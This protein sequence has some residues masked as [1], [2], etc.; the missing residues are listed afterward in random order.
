M[1]KWALLKSSLGGKRDNESAASIHR[2]DGFQMLSKKKKLWPGYH[3]QHSMSLDAADGSDFGP[4]AIALA[5]HCERYFH[6][7]DSA[8]IRVTVAFTG[9]QALVEDFTAN[10]LHCQ[11]HGGMEFECEDT[12]THDTAAT[13]TETET[14]R[15]HTQ[16]LW[17]KS[18]TF[19]P[20]MKRSDFWSYT[21][22][23][24][25]C[26]KETG[27]ASANVLYTR[28]KPATEGVGLNG[29]LSNRLHGIDNT[30]NVCVWASE[31]VLLYTL[32]HNPMVLGS[33][34]GAR[35][36]ELGGGMT[37]LSGL[38]VAVMAPCREVVLTDG[39]PDCVANQ[40]VCLQMTRQS[41]SPLSAAAREGRADR[42]RILF[43]VLPLSFC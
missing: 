38:G 19:E 10:V 37:A 15:I 1:S 39:H 31:S 26:T 36:L 13:A 23:S 41:L 17:I 18:A 28:E 5:G 6:V 12:M 25:L 14:S 32:L 8:E 9:D 27:P 29:L 16:R 20:A 21:L 7:S 4:V 22:P 30:G 42:V 34:H 43:Y 3:F 33:L 2:F 35:V 40:K 24:E 11:K